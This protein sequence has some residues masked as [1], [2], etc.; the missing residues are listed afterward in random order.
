MSDQ[1]PCQLPGHTMTARICTNCY[2]TL[3]QQ[4]KW[5]REKLRKYGTHYRH[6]KCDWWLGEDGKVCTCGLDA[7]LRE[8]G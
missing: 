3:R 4:V 6:P 1:A 2:A 7:T 5:L 8:G